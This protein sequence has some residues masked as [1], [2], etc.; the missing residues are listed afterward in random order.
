MNG[1]NVNWL[2]DPKPR[3]LAARHIDPTVKWALFQLH[4]HVSS[5][6]IIAGGY[7]RDLWHS[8]EPKDIDIFVSDVAED[9]IQDR[10]EACLRRHWPSSECLNPATSETIARLYAEFGI[11]QQ[12][13]F[14]SSKGLPPINLIIGNNCDAPVQI[15]KRFDFGICRIYYDG[16][17]IE[18]S[19]YFTM[20]SDQK[21][22]TFLTG[23][24]GRSL[25]RWYRIKRRYPGWRLVGIE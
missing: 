12:W 16:R 9:I 3:R 13:I 6:A 2:A 25:I 14:R 15:C 24:R 10:L 23:D 22:F 8:V 21:T 7:L 5:S 17:S 18:Y 1:Q 4:K 20:D 19:S 11:R